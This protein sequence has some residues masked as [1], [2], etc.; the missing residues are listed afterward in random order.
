VPPKPK[1]GSAK[2]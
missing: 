1:N 2:K